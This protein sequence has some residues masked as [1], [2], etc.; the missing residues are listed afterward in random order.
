MKKIYNDV[1]FNIDIDKPIVP[2]NDTFTV[3]LR[4][5]GE[6]A[7]EGLKLP[8]RVLNGPSPYGSD[9]V[10]LD[11]T[12]DKDTDYYYL[13]ALLSE[14]LGTNI[15]EVTQTE[16]PPVVLEQVSDIVYKYKNPLDRE[17]ISRTFRATLKAISTEDNLVKGVR[18]FDFV[19]SNEYGYF[20]LD[21]NLRCVKTFKNKMSLHSP[22]DRL[23]N[24]SLYYMPEYTA[25]T[26]F[27]NNYTPPPLYPDPPPKAKIKLKVEAL[28]KNV[29][30]G[31]EAVFKISYE[32]IRKNFKI[33]YQYLDSKDTYNQ[34]DY[35]L[36]DDSGYF[37]FKITVDKLSINNTNTRYLRVWIKDHPKI[38]DVVYVNV[39][40]KEAYNERFIPGEYLIA[41]QPYT[42]YEITL[43]GG[44]GAGGGSVWNRGGN[45]GVNAT[46]EN[47]G[48]TYVEFEGATCIASGTLGGGE[49]HWHNGSAYFDG[50]P[51][52]GG[53][54][55]ITGIS[56][57]FVVKTNISGK[58]G[59]Y[60]QR[61][62]QK[63]GEAITDLG[64]IGFNGAGADGGLGSGDEHFATGGAS[65][66]GGLV[67]CT[68]RNDT[69]RTRDLKLTVGSG[70]LP[71]N[72][73]SNGTWGSQGASGEHGF[74]IIKSI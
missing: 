14:P 15:L 62:I 22:I 37:L 44:A 19:Y 10:L 30:E 17:E 64:D 57:T 52:N 42:S 18:A 65:G 56:N 47:G 29:F 7:K 61:G 55:D 60:V 39:V 2:Y 49:A 71:F 5:S 6:G 54:N 74:A 40:P 31:G 73:E 68:I 8:Y 20:E 4:A 67:I 33:Y 41:L 34:E 72:F 16:G 48:N 63:G 59:V 28:E 53:I 38:Y 3:T 66:S 11:F 21:S 12:Y 1:T 36:T 69:S 25:S 45:W 26:L 35:F 46:G 51:S 9:I 43:I 13:R 24:I 32:N 50:I 23:F 70:G 27:S 58:N